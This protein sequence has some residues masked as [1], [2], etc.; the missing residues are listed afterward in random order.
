MEAQKDLALQWAKSGECALQLFSSICYRSLLRRL[1]LDFERSLESS[2]GRSTVID[3]DVLRDSPQPRPERSRRVV[4]VPIAKRSRDHLLRQVVGLHPGHSPRPVREVR[5]QL[6]LDLRQTL[7]EPVTRGFLE[8]RACGAIGHAG[9]YLRPV[10]RVAKNSDISC[11]RIGS[12]MLQSIA[13]HIR[14]HLVVPV[15]ALSIGLTAARA[16][17]PEELEARLRAELTRAT[18]QTLQLT[19]TLGTDLEQSPFTLVFQSNGRFLADHG[20]GL[21]RDMGFD[22]KHAWGRDHSGRPYELFGSERDTELFFNS[23]I[24]CNWFGELSHWELEELDSGASD[25]LEVALRAEGREFEG[26]VVLDASSLRVKRARVLSGD[27]EASIAFH[28]WGQ[29]E[30]GAYPERMVFS[31]KGARIGEVRFAE[32]GR[33]PSTG[34]EDFAPSFQARPDFSF[35]LKAAPELEVRIGQSGHTF[36]RALLDGRDL[37][38][39]AFDTGASHSV[40]D[41]S[42]A[43]QLEMQDVV[44]SMVRSGAGGEFGFR[45]ARCES[46]TVGPVTWRRPLFGVTDLSALS[47]A[48]GVELAGVF[49]SEMLAQAQWEHDRFAAKLTVHPPNAS[50]EGRDVNWIDA[51][52][53]GGHFMVSAGFEGHEGVFVVDTG[54]GGRGVRFDSEIVERLAL[55]EGRRTSTVTTR[56]FGGTAQ[57]RL[58][59]IGSFE[60]GQRTWK[61]LTAR[62][63]PPAETGWRDSWFYRTRYK[64]TNLAEG[65]LIFSSVFAA[66]LVVLYLVR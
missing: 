9:L 49:G 24:A 37:G 52:Y 25:E 36:V 60:L 28:E 8:S 41:T 53:N 7:F 59:K 4:L 10:R 56:G 16:V 11:D 66:R 17:Q 48:F 21:K 33:A 3:Q 62:F 19:G 1:H 30:L 26:R 2:L 32:F 46:F 44:L 51:R 64:S 57:V 34:A 39:F 47:R 20:E 14:R 6:R 22:G 31:R 38:W 18:D 40:L 61:N 65:S 15:V 12:S 27:V 13:M 29:S 5:P 55:L 63:E 43:A 54:G 50:W 42:A 35:D 45:I 58:G 23:I